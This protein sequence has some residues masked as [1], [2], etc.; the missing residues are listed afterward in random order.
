MHEFKLKDPYINLQNILL[1]K[2]LELS[3]LTP[4]ATTPNN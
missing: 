1:L 4:T 2:E 3:N